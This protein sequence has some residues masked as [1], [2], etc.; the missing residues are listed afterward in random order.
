MKMET[1]RIASD[2]RTGLRIIRRH[3]DFSIINIAGLSMG[4]AIFLLM[5]L[6]VQYELSF[7][8]FHKNFR[9]IYRV[10]E[11]WKSGRA[12]GI[13]PLTP[14]PLA[15]ALAREFPEIAEYARIAPLGRRILSTTD[16]RKKVEQRD[17]KYA[18]PSIFAMF[19]F[20]FLRGDEK[21]ALVA[22]FSMVLAED[23]A[24]VLFPG[25]DPV[26]KLV[27]IGDRLEC[28]VT[29]VV[30]KPPHNSHLQ[31]GYLVSMSSYEKTAGSAVFENWGQESMYSYVLTQGERPPRELNKKIAGFLGRLRQ[32]AKATDRPELFLKPLAKIHLFSN[33]NYE[34]EHAMPYEI[35][36][37]FAGLGL[38]V[39][40][41]AG[42]N[43]TNLSTAF[44]FARAREVGVRKVCG[45]D[46]LTLVRQF[47]SESLLFSFASYLIAL[48]LVALAI[49]EF[50]RLLDTRLSMSLFFD[51]RL[52]A[53]SLAIVLAVGT[54]ASAYPAF[55]LSA[56]R[57]ADV[58]KGPFSPGS[59][60]AMLRK[61]LV[62]SQF[63]FCTFFIIGSIVIYRQG[64]YLRQ[65]DKGFAEEDVWIKGLDHP[66][67]ESME[68]LK[69]LK[70]ELEKSPLVARASISSALP[71]AI[72][73]DIEVDWE[74]GRKD[75][76]LWITWACMDNDFF[77]TYGI[78]LK[79]GRGFSKP[80]TDD[81]ECECLI[82]E[83]ALKR[84]GWSS[85]PLGKKIHGD[86]FTI[87]GVV[88][89]FQSSDMRLGTKPLVLLPLGESDGLFFS[90]KAVGGDRAAA[91]KLISGRFTAIFPSELPEWRL[92]RDYIDDGF[93]SFHSIVLALSGLSLLSILIAAL[94]LYALAARSAQ[95]RTK[96]IGIRKVAGASVP[97]IVL[98][99]MKE[100]L[101][102]AGLG[103][104]ISWPLSFLAW[105][106]FLQN[107]AFRIRFGPGILVASGAIVAVVA[108]V[109]VAYQTIKAATANPVDSLRYE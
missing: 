1:A 93:V 32:A 69:L 36:F 51:W 91:R 95:R 107:F 63:L 70:T 10:E 15:P 64:K 49:P 90:V 78:Q 109:A 57:T 14:A 59:G 99:L 86:R 17:G 77:S 26:G 52:L 79:Q 53:G 31:F 8:R 9:R 21:S 84:F 58:L 11:S 25:E 67:R 29:G 80:F 30:R 83:T 39:L 28:L 94:G 72:Y 102:L 60:K 108:A 105:S 22:P 45:A 73:N 87:V 42:V 98:V 103:I 37:L 71:H 101:R 47:L 81:R 62:V 97:G 6:Y 18:D 5:F 55:L 85:S 74:G 65:M 75:Q 104:L 27:R 68:K 106:A 50:N 3:K 12:Y 100:F 41:L 82:N 46:R 88:R 38:L 89:D 76:T 56:L 24:A 66:G 2:L 40:M 13:Y 33:T 35:V 19:T 48:L 23:T 7:D 4:M 16:F 92:F 43:Y 20:S 34:M 54:A 44:S 96:E 61:I